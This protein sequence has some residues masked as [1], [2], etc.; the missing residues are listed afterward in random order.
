[1]LRMAL[2]SILFLAFCSI[3][4]PQSA[5]QNDLFQ[6]NNSPEFWNNLRVVPVR[7]LDK[8]EDETGNIRLSA[9]F[10]SDVLYTVEKID[11]ILSAEPVDAGED[12]IGFFKQEREWE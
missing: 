7:F 12:K 6:N 10:V 11:F 8:S 2:F 1:M 9:T 5:N 3:A 4:L